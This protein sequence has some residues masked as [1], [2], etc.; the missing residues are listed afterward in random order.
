MLNASSIIIGIRGFSAHRMCRLNQICA[1]YRDSSV[2]K[3]SVYM[4]HLTTIAH[5]HVIKVALVKALGVC[6]AIRIKHTQQYD[7]RVWMVG[8]ILMRKTNTF[9]LLIFQTEIHTSIFL[10]KQDIINKL[11]NINTLIHN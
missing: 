9:H 8:K 5:T 1:H 6:D 4:N 2:Q 7:Y 11:D 3:H 10:L